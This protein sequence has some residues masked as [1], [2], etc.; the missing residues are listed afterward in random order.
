M[1]GGS[2]CAFIKS[3]RAIFIP[4]QRNVLVN[5]PQYI[6]RKLFSFFFHLVRVIDAAFADVRFEVTRLG[7]FLELTRKAK[8]LNKRG[9][10]S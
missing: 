1:R 8:L 7:F 3:K 4:V 5:A 6:L 9:E 10:M 2:T